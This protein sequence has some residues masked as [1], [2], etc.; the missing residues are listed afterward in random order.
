[1]TQAAKLLANLLVAGGTVLFRAATQAYKQAIISESPAW[2][3]GSGGGVPRRRRLCRR[4][5]S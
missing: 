3:M 5:K 2:S 1:M 4:H